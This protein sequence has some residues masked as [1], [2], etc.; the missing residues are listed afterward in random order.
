MRISKLALGGMVA[1]IAMTV[2]ALA[3]HGKVGLWQ[4]TTKMSMPSMP[5]MSRTF[6]SQQCMTA[7]EVK[8]D[9]PPQTSEN[10]QCKMIN[11]KQGASSFSADMVCSGASSGTGHLAVSYDGD[12]HYTGQMSM[13]TKAGD[14]TMNM[15]NTFE[16]KWVSASCGSVIH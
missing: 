3:D 5:S 9:K 16:G 8:S 11:L 7:A 14:Q 12:T 13:V 1:L 4:I 10:S 15:T 6:S 2:S